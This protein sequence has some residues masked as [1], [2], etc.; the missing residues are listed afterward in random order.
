M[1]TNP[2]KPPE[3]DSTRNPLPPAGPGS[4][5]K[6]VL[7]G[8]A[9]DI[10]GS[11]VI[12]FFVAMTYAA[13]LHGNG[14]AESEIREAMRHMPHDTALYVAGLLG[15]LLMSLLGGFVCARVARR[16]EY[17]PGLVMS[18]CSALFGLMLGA[19]SNGDGMLWLLVLTGFAC[20]LLGV[21]FGADQNR[22][23]EAAADP[24]EGASTP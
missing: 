11:M 17:R 6:A 12:G 9:V 24:G 14:M 22:R 7:A 10:G 23:A 19:S 20:N 18:A 21:K 5:P 8:L 4:M 13:Q 3:T 1:S 15:G 2:F 16:G